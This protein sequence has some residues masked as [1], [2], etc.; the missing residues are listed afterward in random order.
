MLDQVLVTVPDVHG[1]VTM[2]AQLD[3]ANTASARAPIHRGFR[4]R[5]TDNGLELYARE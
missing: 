5:S 2:L 4:Y 1:T 3:P